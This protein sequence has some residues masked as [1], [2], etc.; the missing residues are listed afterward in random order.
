MGAPEMHGTSASSAIS[1][2]ISSSS[3]EPLAELSRQSVHSP[4]TIPRHPFSAPLS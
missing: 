4:K 1:A 3:R 2:R